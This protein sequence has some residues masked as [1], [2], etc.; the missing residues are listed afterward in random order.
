[1]LNEVVGYTSAAGDNH[2]KGILADGMYDRYNNFR[3][4]SSNHNK[5]GIKTRR[6]SKV[7]PTN[8][9]ARNMSV[10]RRQANLKN[11]ECIIST[12]E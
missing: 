9:Q 6:N 1:M 3:Y 5:P 2:V 8:Y 7:R 11:A 10:T 12:N 4:L